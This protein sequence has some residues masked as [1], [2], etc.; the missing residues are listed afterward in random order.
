MTDQMI[1]AD[2]VQAVADWLLNEEMTNGGLDEKIAP[3]LA[4]HAQTCREVRAKL[5]ALLHPTLA[6]MTDEERATCKRMQ[7]DVAG[8]S[9]RYVILDPSDEDGEAAL[10]DPDGRLAW[11][12]PDYVTPRPDLP[13]MEWPG[14]EKPA[15]VPALPEGW[16][17]ADHYRIG[18]VIVTNPTPNPGGHVYFVTSDETVPRG[19]GWGFCTPN[20]LTY[21]DEEPHHDPQ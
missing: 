15:P 2:K 11:T 5:L 9:T 14:T 4:A 10:I 21:L 12:F 1:P 16:L 3:Q 20:E 19:S 8:H 13:R 18:R 17:F 6:D 7:A